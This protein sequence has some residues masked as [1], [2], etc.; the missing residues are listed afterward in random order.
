MTGTERR[1]RF[2]SLLGL[3]SVSNIEAW[4]EYIDSGFFVGFHGTFLQIPG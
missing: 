2:I 1:R 3:Y 4:T